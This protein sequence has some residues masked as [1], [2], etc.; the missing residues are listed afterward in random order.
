[1]VRA[2]W[3]LSAA[4]LK[5]DADAEDILQDVWYQLSAV[6][7][8]EPIEQ[9]GAWLYKVATNKIIDKNR[10]KPEELFDLNASVMKMTMRKAP[11]SGQSCLPKAPHRKQNIS[12]T[13]FGSSYF[14]RWMNCPKSKSRFLYGRSSMISLLVK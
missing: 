10:K 13:Y 11:I 6:V 1:M 9:T 4:G 14:L 8:A 5:S 3:A 2:C 7:N 12:A